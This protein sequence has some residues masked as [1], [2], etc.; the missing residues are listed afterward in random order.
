MIASPK[1]QFN[2]V[3]VWK[4]ITV[5]ELAINCDRNVK[6]IFQVLSLIGVKGDFEPNT[7][8][9]SVSVI[10]DVVEKMGLRVQMKSKYEKKENSKLEKEM[11]LTKR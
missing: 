8:I 4:G 3:Q 5:N 1:K 7:S 10:K 9:V 6:Q 11:E 2:K